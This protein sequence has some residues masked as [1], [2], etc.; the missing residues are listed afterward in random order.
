[1]ILEFTVKIVDSDY[2]YLKHNNSLDITWTHQDAIIWLQ[3]MNY[4]YEYSEEQ[5][6]QTVDWVPF[7]QSSTF[8]EWHMKL[9]FT[10]DAHTLDFLLLKWPRIFESRAQYETITLVND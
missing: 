8:L 6:A 2:L 10:I 4:Y 3:E 1:M 7:S 5:V 9:K